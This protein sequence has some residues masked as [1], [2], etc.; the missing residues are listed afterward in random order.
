MPSL[1]EESEDGIAGVFARKFKMIPRR[2]GEDV[3]NF[4]FHES[5]DGLK[6]EKYRGTAIVCRICEKKKPFSVSFDG[7][8]KL[9]DKD[10]KG[11][12][13][14]GFDDVVVFASPSKKGIIA[15]EKGKAVISEFVV[16]SER[17]GCYL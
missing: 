2:T 13:L 5:K 16:I 11:I 1:N 12:V 3:P 15:D 9:L 7:L 14:V 17:K 4:I 10:P 8:L 6:P